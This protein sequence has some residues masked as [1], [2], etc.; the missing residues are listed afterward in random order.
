M[1][2]RCLEWNN[3]GL[4]IDGRTLTH[5]R[6]ADDI[7]LFAKTPE[8]LNRMLNELASESA[9]VGLKLNL[10]KTKVMTNGNKS[11]I[12]VGESQI[13]YA[14]EYMYLGQ[15]ISPKDNINKEIE[16]RITNSWKRYWGL[17]E[18]NE[19]KYDRSKE[20]GQDKKHQH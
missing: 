10:E 7:V 11:N 5:L 18:V 13:S 2:L 19:E 20:E 4:N 1:I 17:R 3:L 15:L 9:K 14:E 6:F 12:G 16:R 8:D